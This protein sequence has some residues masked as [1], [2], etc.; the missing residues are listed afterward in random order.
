MGL[1]FVVCCNFCVR[2]IVRAR[3]VRKRL[4]LFVSV[5]FEGAVGLWLGDRYRLR[6]NFRVEQEAQF[7]GHSLITR[8]QE[9][10]ERGFP[11]LAINR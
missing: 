7:S 1:L 11:Q 10:F 9:A 5:A 3:A 4:L 6:P 8:D 2:K